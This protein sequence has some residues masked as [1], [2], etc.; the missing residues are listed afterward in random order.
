VRKALS[1]SLSACFACGLGLVSA[2]G[3]TQRVTGQTRQRPPEGFTCALN[4]IT[5][6]TGVVT[7]YRRERGQT[8]LRIST[9]WDTT[10]NVTVTHA[11]TDDPSA[12][13]RYAGK[14]FTTPDWTRIEKSK[15][16]LLDGVRASAWVCTN[17]KVLIDWGV[18]KERD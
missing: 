9:D 4:D 11:D 7:R 3:D 12:S 13:F 6:Y 15:G 1:F 17:G 14:P 5:V 10:E 8:T 2:N 18:P 16:V